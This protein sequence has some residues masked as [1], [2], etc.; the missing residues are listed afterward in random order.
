M[1]KGI[2]NVVLKVAWIIVIV[3]NVIACTA[4]TTGTQKLVAATAGLAVWSRVVVHCAQ[5][6]LVRGRVVTAINAS[7]AHRD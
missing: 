4:C 6:A 3:T 1:Y 2:K 7:L 5:R